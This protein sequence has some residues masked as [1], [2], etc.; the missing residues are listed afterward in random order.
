[1][2]NPPLVSV[3]IPSYQHS[4]Y[5]QQ[6]VEAVMD[7]SYP[8]VEL[9]VIDDG[10]TD[11]SPELLKKLA[12]QYNFRLV[13][14]ANR[15]LSHTLNEGIEIANGKYICICASD[16]YFLKNKLKDQTEFMESNPQYAAS[17][18]K[19]IHFDDRGS[20]KTTN[21]SQCYSGKIFYRLLHTNFVPAV[22]QMY[23]RE[24]FTKVGG[25]NPDLM[26]EDWDMLLRV[27]WK[28]EIGFLNQPLAM[29]REHDASLSNPRH[30]LRFYQ[31]EKL[32]LESW[33]EK[34]P[35]RKHLPSWHVRWFCQLAD[36]NPQEASLYLGAALKKFYK[37][38]VWRALKKF[39]S[40]KK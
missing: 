35:Y 9:I 37:K 27:A 7:Q 39:Y 2:R 8:A 4:A 32:I 38:R 3:L 20:Q 29:R 11:G 16:D 40:A 21:A 34:E 31:N 17:Y 5:V 30:A 12:D 13:C 19:A 15:G 24:I 1:M 22:T 6:S 36:V 10:S 23:H 25:F 33:M 14:R 26:I 28:H 18:G